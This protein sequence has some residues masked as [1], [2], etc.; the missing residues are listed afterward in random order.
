[1]KRNVLLLIIVIF[2]SCFNNKTCNAQ[3]NNSLCSVVKF[4]YKEEMRGFNVFDSNIFGIKTELNKA[5][6][7]ICFTFYSKPLFRYGYF[8]LE[9]SIDSVDFHVLK[10]KK[11][12]NNNN[13]HTY[14][15][16]EIFKYYFN[17]NQAI[18]FLTK[19]KNINKVYYRLILTID[20]GENSL[21]K[22]SIA[23]FVI[24]KNFLI[25]KN[26]EFNR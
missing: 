3:E 17:D 26:N 2:M 14:D 5:K 24:D 20:N 19:N 18:D 12:M 10:C 22:K 21:L 15:E 8:S 16:S 1:M 9:Y 13:A 11:L 4:E 23:N 25:N 6:D 7:S